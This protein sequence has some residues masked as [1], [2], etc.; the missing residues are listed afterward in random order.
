MPQISPVMLSSSWALCAQMHEDLCVEH[1]LSI[2]KI[3]FFFSFLQK[4][5]NENVKKTQPEGSDVNH[6]KYIAY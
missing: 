4:N 1:Q 5:N 2:Q 3:I 6:S